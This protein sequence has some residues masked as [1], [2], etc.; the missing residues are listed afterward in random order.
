MDIVSQSS[1]FPHWQFPFS[2]EYQFSGQKGQGST[3]LLFSSCLTDFFAW[4]NINAIKRLHN[5]YCPQVSTPQNKVI[6][7]ITPLH[8]KTQ[9]SCPQA[10]TPQNTTIH[11]LKPLHLKTQ[12]LLPSSFYAS[13]YNHSWSINL[14]KNPIPTLKHKHFKRKLTLFSNLYTSKHNHSWPRAS[15]SQNT[16]IPSLKPLHI[17]AQRFLSSSICNSKHNY[18]CSPAPT[19]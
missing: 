10:S 6:P 7:D 8:F 4:S 15:T 3:W 5:Y 9:H 17:K 11:A 14:I 18:Y 2:L 12:L 19:I 16:T 1:H 13:K